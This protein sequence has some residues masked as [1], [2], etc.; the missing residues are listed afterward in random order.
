MDKNTGAGYGLDM[1]RHRKSL[2]ITERITR[3]IGSVPSIFLHTIFFL[4]CLVA[5]WLRLFAFDTILLVLNTIVSLEAIYLALF[6]Q[7][8]VNE[9]TESLRGVEEDIDEIQEDV[10]ELGEDV[11]EIQEDIEEM[12]EDIEEMSEDDAEDE[13]RDREHTDTLEHL[14]ASV[15]QILAD[16]ESLKK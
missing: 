15:R 10:E 3:A 12:S 1:P 5:I 7:L 11:D 9:N 8:T 6:I 16:L 13:R 4:A 2:R 14:T